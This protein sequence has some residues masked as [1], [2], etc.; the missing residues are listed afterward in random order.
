MM[1]KATVHFESSERYQGWEAR[2]RSWICRCTEVAVFLQ[3]TGSSPRQK[4]TE[5]WHI[6]TH[7]IHSQQHLRSQPLAATRMADKNITKPIRQLS[8]RRRSQL[9]C[10]LN[11]NGLE[12]VVR[13]YAFIFF[14]LTNGLKVT[15]LHHTAT[16]NIT[17][18]LKPKLLMLPKI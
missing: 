11:G 3:Q 12:K 14:F 1:M 6:K 16:L 18:K 5:A 10:L 4:R 2:S 17:S 9:C 15:V 8:R 13:K 7:T